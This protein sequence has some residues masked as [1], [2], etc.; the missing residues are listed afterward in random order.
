MRLRAFRRSAADEGYL[1]G[2]ADAVK[3]LYWAKQ[4]L[5]APRGARPAGRMG[6]Y[7]WQQSGAPADGCRLSP[8]TVAVPVFLPDPAPAY[9]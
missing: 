5:E 4:A 3:Q 7:T 2:E 9:R 1:L 8:A 6:Y